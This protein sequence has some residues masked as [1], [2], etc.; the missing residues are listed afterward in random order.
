MIHSPDVRSYTEAIRHGVIAAITETARHARLRRP[1]L[2]FVLAVGALLALLASVLLVPAEVQAQSSGLT[3][4]TNVSATGSGDTVTVTWTDGRG[5]AGHLVLLYKSD[6]SGDP[7]L[8]TAQGSSHTFHDVPPGVYVAVVIAF[9]TD[10]NR[11]FTVSSVVTL[12]TGS[13]LTPPSNVVVTVN[14]N[15]VVVAWSAAREAAGYMVLLFKSD[16]SGTPIAEIASGSPHIVSDVP[17]GDYIAVVVSFDAEGDYLYQIG[18]TVGVKRLWNLSAIPSLAGGNNFLVTLSWEPPP[19]VDGHLVYVY[20]ALAPNEPIRNVYLPADAVEATVA[21]LGGQTY[22]FEVC[23]YVGALSLQSTCDWS[24]RKVFSVGEQEIIV[25]L[26]LTLRENLEVVYLVDTSG[27]MS[28]GKINKLK[29]TLEIIR[30]RAPDVRN[31]RAALVDFDSSYRVVFDLTETSSGS[32]DEEW[33]SGIRSLRAGGGTRMYGALQFASDLLPDTPVCPT[34][35][36]CRK[37]EIILMS[38]GRA[39]DG[40]LGTSTI[41]A[42]ISKGVVVRTFAFGAD[43]DRRAL[44]RIADRTGGHFTPAQ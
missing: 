13:G 5:A 39:G 26:P 7:F 6:F 42:L 3:A 19:D 43:A 23:A 1:S 17:D 36:S 31:T 18:G 35:D 29:E 22:E 14:G 15:T 37:R 40:Y 33:N 21:L 4:P 30:D 27:S 10:A 44:K 8:A 34:P 24:G 32:W 11:L 25:A 12:W 28:G 2:S 38:D 16:F 9:D 41:A 20:N